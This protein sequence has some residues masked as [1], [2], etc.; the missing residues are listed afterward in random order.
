[1]GR[2]VNKSRFLSVSLALICLV[3]A[4]FAPAAYAAETGQVT[5][6]V[7]QTFVSGGPPAPPIQVFTYE[8]TPQTAGAPMPAGGDEGGYTFTIAGNVEMQTRPINFPGTG[9]YVYTLRCVTEDRPGYT[10][11]RREYTV[12]VY[13]TE[14]LE[15]FLIYVSD[16]TKVTELSFAHSYRT[17]ESS[18]RPPSPSPGP[19]SPSPDG[20]K[21]GD[22]PKTGDDS[23]PILW[24][25]LI[26]ISSASLLS[27]IWVAWRLRDRRRWED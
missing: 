21:G 17:P 8:L 14:H 11:D 6:T 27:L 25:A 9:L 4:L 1:M 20:P 22:A 12:E 19:P 16:G 13:V 2:I 10:I 7:R 3:G 24:I 23:N 18:P 26:A 15:I 5:L